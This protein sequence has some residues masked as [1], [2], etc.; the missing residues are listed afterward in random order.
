[1]AFGFN[2]KE[3]LFAL[4]AGGTATRLIGAVLAVRASTLVGVAGD[5]IMAS[6]TPEEENNGLMVVGGLLRSADEA[7]CLVGGSKSETPRVRL[8]M[9]SRSVE[10]DRRRANFNIIRPL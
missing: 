8:L 1:L 4:L 3:F 6:A 5:S 9:D 10:L 2:S 7:R